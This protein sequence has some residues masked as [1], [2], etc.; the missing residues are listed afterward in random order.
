MLAPILVAPANDVRP[1]EVP[2]PAVL[3]YPA[4][5]PGPLD[6][7]RLGRHRQQRAEQPSQLGHLRHTD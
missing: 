1:P 4:L 2:G 7:L 6:Q 3:H 5:K